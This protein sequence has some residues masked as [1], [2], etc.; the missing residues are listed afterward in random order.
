MRPEK[1]PNPKISRIRHKHSGKQ[2]P[3]ACLKE[4][5][6]C[7]KPETFKRQTCGA[8]PNDKLFVLGGRDGAVSFPGMR[9]AL[10]ERGWVEHTEVRFLLNFSAVLGIFAERETRIVVVTCEDLKKAGPLEYL[11]L[12]PH[13]CSWRAQPST[14]SGAWRHRKSISTDS[15]LARLSITLHRIDT[16]PQRSAWR[17]ASAL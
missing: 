10:L 4:T 5:A 12:E 6:S 2:N 3:H 1:N 15:T 9:E 7:W 13:L 17:G 11:N 14:S 8:G 16:W